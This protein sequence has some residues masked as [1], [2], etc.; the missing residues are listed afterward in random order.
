MKNWE[1][2]EK[3][4]FE[5]LKSKYSNKNYNFEHNGGFDSTKSDI[6]LKK[7]GIACFYIESKMKASQ[8]GQF[9]VKQLE[10]RF[11]NSEN[12]RH[13]KSL[14]EDVIID[15]M[16][17]DFESYTNPGTA[18][19]NLNIEKD[20]FYEWICNFYKSKNVKYFIVEKD[21]GKN[22]LTSDNFIIFP[23][24]HFQKYF[25]V[26]ATYR[27]KKSGSNVP[28]KNYI[29]EI[30]NSLENQKITHSKIE[31]KDGKAYINLLDKIYKFKTQGIQY[32]YQFNPI[33]DNLFEIRWLSNTKNAN[34]IFSISLI[35]EQA[36]NDLIEFEAEFLPCVTYARYTL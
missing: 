9:V 35:K 16:N 7:N 29:E 28:S 30:E 2:C 17:E 21:V 12:N 18:G 14:I 26:F 8:C 11:V 31:F 10:N 6:L 22:K 33:K 24:Q 3:E 25:D 32:D 19:K 20:Y 5:Y 4:C 36:E 27:V 34:V 23:I 1:I 13:Q 15:K